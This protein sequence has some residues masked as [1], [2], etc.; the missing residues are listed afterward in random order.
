MLKDFKCITRHALTNSLRLKVTG[1][2]TPIRLA[3]ERE[4]LESK[5]GTLSIEK[6]REGFNTISSLLRINIPPLIPLVHVIEERTFLKN[7]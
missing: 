1:I 7:N 5:G 2:S 6:F 3:G 4:L